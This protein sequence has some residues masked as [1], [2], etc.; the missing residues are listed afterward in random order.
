MKL[1][2]TISGSFAEAIDDQDII[3]LK[4]DLEDT[5][6]IEYGGHGVIVEVERT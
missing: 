1:H 2:I 5:C 3:D 4:E 6:R